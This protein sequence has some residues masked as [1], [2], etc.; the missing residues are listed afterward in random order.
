MQDQ[1]KGIKMKRLSLIVGVSLL[2]VVGVAPASATAGPF[3]PPS[4]GP[5]GTEWSAP[6][7]PETPALVGEAQAVC[8]LKVCRY[9]VSCVA[10]PGSGT[11]PC[12]AT[13]ALEAN[14]QGIITRP[15]EHQLDED[16]E[17]LQPWPVTEGV[18]MAV[19]TSK[20]L[21]LR[22]IPPTKKFFREKI[23]QGKRKIAGDWYANHILRWIPNPYPNP[24]DFLF[25]YDRSIKIK[26]KV[27]K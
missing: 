7:P 23:S 25:Q 22:T 24:P 18:I 21:V 16:G 17:L 15:T 4:Y 20:T 14:G 8:T 2:A 13:L 12:V 19:G 26:I 10:I 5:G 1:M 3:D 11:A 27:K 6:P 9:T